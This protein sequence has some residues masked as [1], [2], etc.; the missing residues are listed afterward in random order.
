MYYRSGT[1]MGSRQMLHVSYQ[2]AA[3]FCVKGHHGH[4]LEII[5]SDQKI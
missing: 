1:G 4:R 2:T 5:I 3:L